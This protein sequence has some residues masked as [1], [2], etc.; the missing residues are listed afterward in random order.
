M[1]YLARDTKPHLH[2]NTCSLFWGKPNL[3][4]GQFNQG[5]TSEHIDDV[6]C[7]SLANMGIFLDRGEVIDF[8]LSAEDMIKAAMTDALELAKV[9]A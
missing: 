1:F 6:S 8:E 7:R 3:V 5:E 9:A 2:T 4:D